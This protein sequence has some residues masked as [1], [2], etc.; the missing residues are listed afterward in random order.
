[1]KTMSRVAATFLVS[2]SMLAAAYAQE[3]RP[4][5]YNICGPCDKPCFEPYWSGMMGDSM[6]GG[7]DGASLSSVTLVQVAD[8]KPGYPRKGK[9]EAVKPLNDALQKARFDAKGGL[10]YG[11]DQIIKAV[12]Y[13]RENTSDPLV[14]FV[15][16]N[17][18]PDPGV[19]TRIQTVNRLFV[20][21][22][23]DRI[24]LY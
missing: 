24:T 14:G 18:T 20:R 10:I 9:R 7:G 21:S 1:M 4:G 5:V 3:C 16:P 13:L 11:Q 6:S 17:L 12:K 22:S 23:K 15:A 19:N 8:T 2:A